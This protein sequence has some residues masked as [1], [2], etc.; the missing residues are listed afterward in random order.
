VRVIIR[1]SLDGDKGGLTTVLGNVLNKGGLPKKKRTG[2]YEGSHDVSIS[3]LKS[4]MDSFWDKL[5]GQK[6]AK[7][8][9]FWMYVDKKTSQTTSKTKSQKSRVDEKN[10]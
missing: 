5:E 10:S 3:S 7:L 6:K 4:M 8:D 1:F 9:H 2:T